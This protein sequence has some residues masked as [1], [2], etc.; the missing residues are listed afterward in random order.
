MDN[1]G[2]RQ[3]RNQN[4]ETNGQTSLVPKKIDWQKIF[5]QVNIDNVGKV[6]KKMK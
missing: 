6:Q 4:F 1:L 2:L 5:V 3:W